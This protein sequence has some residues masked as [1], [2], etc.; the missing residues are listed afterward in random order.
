MWYKKTEHFPWGLREVRP[1]LV[2]RG[3]TGFFGVFGMYCKY[4]IPNVWYNNVEAIL[5][6]N[7]MQCIRGTARLLYWDSQYFHRPMIATGKTN[8]H[9]FSPIPPT[10]RC[11]RHHLSSPKSCMLGL[12]LL[13][14]RAIH[15][16]GTDRRICLLI[17]SSAHCATRLALCIAQITLGRAST[18]C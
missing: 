1:L 4:S 10:C 15:A 2:A 8:F 13:H 18:S 9:R 3:L 11:N 12:Q 16:H 17:W 14:Q 5:A 6:G 7:L